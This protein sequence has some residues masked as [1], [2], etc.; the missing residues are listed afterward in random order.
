MGCCTAINK[1]N[2]SKNKYR[3]DQNTIQKPQQTDSV[4]PVEINEI[5]VDDK[6]E[7][8]KRDERKDQPDDGKIEIQK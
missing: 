4:K 6:A 2:D 7:I 5:K 3:V 8:K 1:E